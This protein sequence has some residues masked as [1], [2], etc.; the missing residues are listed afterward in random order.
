MLIF[1]RQ[2]RTATTNTFWEL[3]PRFYQL[4]KTKKKRKKKTRIRE[5]WKKN[6]LTFTET[7]FSLMFPAE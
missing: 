1:P 5:R 6:T 3:F 2:K 4:I 7:V